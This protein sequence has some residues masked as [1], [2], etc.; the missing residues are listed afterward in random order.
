MTTTSSAN[1]LPEALRL[2]DLKPYLSVTVFECT[3]ADPEPAFG[4]LR[5]FLRTSADDKGRALDVRVSA[6]V[7]VGPD[8]IIEEIGSLETFGLTAIYGVS[9]TLYKTPSWADKASGI[10]DAVNQ[11][12]VL[13]HRNKLAAVFSDITSKDQLGK[14][15]AKDVTP[16]RAIPTDILAATV[17][18]DA[19]ML[20]TRGTHRRRVTKADTKALGGLRIQEALDPI[21]DGSFALTAAK[22]HYQ[23][24]DKSAVLRD[25][26]TFSSK[27]SISWKATAYFAE[28]LRATA[29]AFDLIEKS[30]AD[31][32]SVDAPFPQLAVREK[33]LSRVRGAFD[34]HIVDPDHVRAEPDSNEEA[35]DRAALLQD[36][37]IETRGFPDSA[38]AHVDV[39]HDGVVAGTLSLKPV[40]AGG[41]FTLQVGYV[42]RPSAEVIVREIKDALKDGDLVTVYY[43]SG[44]AFTGHDITKRSMVGSTFPNIR[45]EDFTG[46]KVDKEKPKLD[47]D[48]LHDAIARNGDD[49]LFA[50]VVDQFGDEWLLCDDG[51]GEI[52]DFLHLDN[53]G[54]LTAIHVKAAD[55]RSPSRRIAVA[56]FDVVVSQAEKN[57]RLL[58][59]ETLIDRLSQP[60]PTPRAVWHTK[61]RSTT[62]AFV[63]Q[64]RART[65]TDTTRVMIVQPHL[66]KAVYDTARAAIDA[67]RLD[68]NAQS[69]ILLD[70][71]LNSTRRTVTGFWEDLIVVG[72]A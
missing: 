60:R 39:G 12:T 29:E 15:A 71:L 18:G 7:D 10:I 13:V 56:R 26:V 31:G 27:S 33:D 8:D 14:W 21:D 19:R 6:D 52:A 5:R 57:V 67:E 36:A 43:E 16:Y 48:R 51:A 37:L 53:D 23:P 49:S 11:L 38:T 61:A 46:F 63:D 2:A 42:G 70:N 66:L 58:D 69:L 4:A 50:W 44:H 65:A 35:V 30:L 41:G 32:D 72:C 9:R 22:I 55:T 62:A 64:L 68:H 47:Q 1:A 54:T 20:W 25:N 40:P 3:D 28:F 45:F 17:E 59:N 34:V 24:D